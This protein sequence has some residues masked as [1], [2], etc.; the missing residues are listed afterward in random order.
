MHPSRLE[1]L[2]EARLTFMS[3][4]AP[5]ALFT[6][7][8]VVVCWAAFAAVLAFRKR[9]PQETEAKRDRLSLLGILLQMFAYFLVWFQRPGTPFLPPVAALSG[10]LGIVFSLF[11][12]A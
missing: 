8:G 11:T 10:V 6:L 9:P 3:E 5:I 2:P 4:P 1:S 7:C 12:V